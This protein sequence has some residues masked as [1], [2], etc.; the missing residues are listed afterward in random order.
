MAVTGTRHD[1]IRGFKYKI[2]LTGPHPIG[3][4]QLGAQRVSGLKSKTE[5]VKYRDGDDYDGEYTFVGPTTYNNVTL[6]RGVR[7]AGAEAAEQ[8]MEWCQL[9][10]EAAREGAGDEIDVYGSM[11]IE[12]FRRNMAEFTLSSTRRS[13]R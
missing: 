2:T 7:P 6:E 9:I 1:P 12:V 3:V 8:L 11:M 5:A 13:Y 4:F 10:Q